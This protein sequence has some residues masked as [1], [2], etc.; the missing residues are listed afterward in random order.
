ML[1]KRGQ[2]IYQ[3][4][5][6]PEMRLWN[7][8]FVYIK[9]T[10]IIQTSKLVNGIKLSDAAINN[11]NDNQFFLDLRIDNKEKNKLD[12]DMH[13]TLALL[14]KIIESIEDFCNIY[15]KNKHIKVVKHKAI[16]PIVQKLYK[17]YTA[18]WSLYDLLFILKK[19]YVD[20]LL[21]KYIQKS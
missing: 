8:C 21:D 11:F 13:I 10:W 12:I 18:F 1:K 16:T 4:S 7:Y 17:I 5:K 19:I 9:N 14:N 20:L 2:T 3:L 6:N 15:I